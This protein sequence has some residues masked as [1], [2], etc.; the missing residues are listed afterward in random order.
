ML[1][2][3]E[4]ILLVCLFMVV[5]RVSGIKWLVSVSSSQFDSLAKLKM[6]L[7]LIRFTLLLINTKQIFVQ[8][9]VTICINL[10]ERATN[11]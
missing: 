4:Q 8:L 1:A 10:A 3:I 2:V 7:T 6:I 5:C 9:L 11:K